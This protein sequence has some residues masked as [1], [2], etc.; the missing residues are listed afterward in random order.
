MAEAEKKK[1]KARELFDPIRQ[2]AAAK[3]QSNGKPHTDET[4]AELLEWLQV[5]E[6]AIEGKRRTAKS[7]R[8][9][10]KV[11]IGHILQLGEDVRVYRIMSNNALIPDVGIAVSKDNLGY[12][13]RYVCSFCTCSLSD[14]W[15]DRIARGLLGYRMKMVGTSVQQVMTM[16]YR[17]SENLNR[18]CHRDNRG[19]P[20]EATFEE[21]V[22]SVYYWLVSMAFIGHPNVS[23]QF[24]KGVIDSAMSEYSMGQVVVGSFVSF[25]VKQI[26]PHVA[27][28]DD[29]VKRGDSDPVGAPVKEREPLIEMVAGKVVSSDG[30]TVDASGGP[31][32]TDGE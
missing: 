17:H 22:A 20:I 1:K 26:W 11:G 29:Q 27:G 14:K 18:F 16:R 30:E 9:M 19:K 25:N 13:D 10:K 31:S 4:R 5:V 2:A 6:G 24:R 12:K 3:T 32:E 15:S 7:N 21:A 23:K 8:E 28:S